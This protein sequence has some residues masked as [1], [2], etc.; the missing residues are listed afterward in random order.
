MALVEIA[1][2]SDISEAQVAA[3]ALRASGVFVF[4]QNENWSQTQA[5]LTLAMG[6]VRLFTTTDEAEDAREFVRA[7]RSTPTVVV[8]LN[9][10]QGVLWTVATLVVSTVLG[11]L[12]P[13]RPRSL[14]R[15]PPD[16]LA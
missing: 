6:G 10:V 8:P 2:F 13:L 14:E 15:F 5:Y 4:L 16:D 12:M 1:R 3:S 9:P 7:C 11:I